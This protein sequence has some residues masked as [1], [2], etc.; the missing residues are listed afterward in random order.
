M[1]VHKVT[2]GGKEVTPL[3]IIGSV[4]QNQF[5]N[6]AYTIIDTQSVLLVDIQGSWS[7]ETNIQYSRDVKRHAKPLIGRR[8]AMLILLDE[9]KMSTQD[10]VPT[11]QEL[12]QWCHNYGI[13]HCALVYHHDALK[14]YQL[15]QM[16]TRATE[17]YQTGYFET[18]AD[19][20]EW[21][22]K[23]G[24]AVHSDLCEQLKGYRKKLAN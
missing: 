19:A 4:D 23:G 15:S 2:V 18:I 10:S 22:N 1:N 21:L 24:Y 8:W 20:C 3:S 9:W 11:I 13:T 7:R 17:S 6:A 16:L 5:K 14:T 12:S